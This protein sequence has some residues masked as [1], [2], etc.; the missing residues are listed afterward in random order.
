MGSLNATVPFAR[1][2]VESGKATLRCFRAYVL[3]PKNTL[4]ERFGSIP[5]LYSGVRFHC[6]DVDYPDPLVFWC[7]GRRRVVEALENSG[8]EV[9]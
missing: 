9:R 4:C 1:L 3:T 6:I 2:V 8:F 5:L 7:L